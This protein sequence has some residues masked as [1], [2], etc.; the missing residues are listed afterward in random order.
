M[1]LV[2]RY[3]F[4]PKQSAGHCS[5]VELPLD[6]VYFGLSLDGALEVDVIALLDVVGL[7]GRAEAE[8][9]ARQI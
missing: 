3:I 7:K 1:K 4:R 9:D 5:Y 2:E 8:G 6:F